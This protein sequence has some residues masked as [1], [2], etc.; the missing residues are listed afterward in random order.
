[1]Q[2]H[3]K[4]VDLSNSPMD[5][6]HT[7]PIYPLRL[8]LHDYLTPSLNTLLGKHWSHL[9]REKQKAA[10]ALKCALNDTPPAS[11]TPTTWPEDANPSLINSATMDS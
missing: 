6:G 1:M 8:I 11:S 5:A 7:P 2:K 10:A 3:S 9:H 4:T